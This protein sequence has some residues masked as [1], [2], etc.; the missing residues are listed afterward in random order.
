MGKKHSKNEVPWEPAGWR[1]CAKETGLD[2]EVMS[3]E[4]RNENTEEE[5]WGR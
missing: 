2:L 5:K 1:V 4:K 3:V